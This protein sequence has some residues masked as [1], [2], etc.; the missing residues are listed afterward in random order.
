VTVTARALRAAAVPYE[1][2]DPPMTDDS[3]TIALRATVIGGDRLAN[4]YEAISRGQ[5]T[6]RIKKATGRCPKAAT[7]KQ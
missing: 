5:P 4:D 3:E 7:E 1:N 2:F 6:V